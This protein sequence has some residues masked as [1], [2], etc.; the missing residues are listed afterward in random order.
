VEYA[1][2]LGYTVVD[3]ISIL[4]THFSEVVKKHAHELFTRQD[5]KLFCDRVGAEQPKL[6]EEF[7]PKQLAIVQ[8]V[9]QNLLHEQVP[10]RDAVS[11]LESMGE[12]LLTTRNPVLV[13]EYVRQHIRRLLISPYLNNR[14]EL[15]AYFADSTVEETLAAAAEHGENNSILAL[16]PQTAREL[17]D[18]FRQKLDPKESAVIVSSPGVRYFLRQIT[19][20]AFPSLTVVSQNE[21]PPDVSVV[22]LGVI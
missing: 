13:T 2:S 15:L 22:S 14:G 5:A 7:I 9:L 18:R 21:M 20:C 17:L 6:V 11:I 10:I 12:A 19:E 8:R 4:G 16:A 1:Q 3:P